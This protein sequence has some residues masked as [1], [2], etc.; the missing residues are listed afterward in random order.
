MAT[1]LSKQLLS[2]TTFR[3]G[4][5]DNLATLDIYNKNN[6]NIVNSIQSIGRLY[7]VDLTNVMRG[8]A[9]ISRHFPI[10]NKIGGEANQLVSV[11][12]NNLIARISSISKNISSSVSSMGS[13]FLDS[14][15][16]SGAMQSVYTVVD[17]IRSEVTK[18]DL[19]SL[20]PIVKTIQEVAGDPAL[21]G[22][23]DR[24]SESALYIGLI[25]E[26]SRHGIPNSF[27]SVVGGISDLSV[28][29]NVIQ[30][31]LPYTVT[32]SDVRM[33]QSIAMND[34]SSMS[35]LGKISV[36]RDFISRYRS[37]FGYNK[38]ES[39]TEFSDMYSTFN[40][41]HPDW[42][43]KTIT[44]AGADTTILDLSKITAGSADFKESL[45]NYFKINEND[46]DLLMILG[47]VFKK[48]TVED[49]LKKMLPLLVLHDPAIY[50]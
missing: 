11:N 17:G 34:T 47:S 20:K 28:R 36:L 46:T 14:V 45:E 8:G 1:S 23:V 5:N 26:A 27:S 39:Y 4:I 29:N 3:T 40:A 7:D 6:T 50:Q 21:M 19:S 10:I 42:N 37:G 41:I 49:E 9:L 2:P 32:N 48:T 25:S 15:K 30:N 18:V 38:N 24:G 22:L 33:L 35:F 43:K 12:T 44:N 16:N 13:G 31:V